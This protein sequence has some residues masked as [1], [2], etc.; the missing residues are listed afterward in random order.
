MSTRAGPRGVVYGGALQAED[1]NRVAQAVSRAR[2]PL[3]IGGGSGKFFKIYVSE[4]AFQVILKP[5]FPYSIT[6]VLSKVR[7]SNPNGVLPIFHTYVG[8]SYFLG[9]KILNS[10]IFRGFQ[11]K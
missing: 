7:H 3:L 5:F 10:N 8:A 9:F 1:L 6:S 4:N 11:K 2:K